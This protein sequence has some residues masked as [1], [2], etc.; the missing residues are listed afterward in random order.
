MQNL[1]DS[2]YKR[3]IFVCTNIKESGKCCGASSSSSETLDKLRTI[4]KENNLGGKGGVRISKSGCLGRCS[5]GPCLAIYPDNLWY[6]VETIDEI[7]LA[8]LVKI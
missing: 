7:E 1:T 3:H 2:Y 6:N 5:E 4:V 8:K